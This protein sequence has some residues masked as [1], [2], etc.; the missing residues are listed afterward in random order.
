[1]LCA[2]SIKL[3]NN[4]EIP[5]TDGL[6]SFIILEIFSLDLIHLLLIEGGLSNYV[7]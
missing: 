3:E 6:K 7:I 5:K 1:M 2:E 4:T